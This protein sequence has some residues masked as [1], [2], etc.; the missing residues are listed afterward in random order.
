M[1]KILHILPLCLFAG[2][3]LQQYNPPAIASPAT[4]LVVEG[5]IDSG[6]DSTTFTLTQTFPLQTTGVATPTPQLGAK[7]TVQGSDN[8]SYPLGEVGGGVYGAQLAGL[9]PSVTYRLFIVTT[10]GKQYASDYVPLVSNPPI[11]SINWVRN[12]DGVQIY[13]NT[14]DPTGNAKYFRW[15]Y[16]ETWEF[17]SP[18][19]QIEKY[20]N[21]QLEAYFPN[22]NSTC[23]RSDVSTDILIASSTQ[24]SQDVLYEVPLVLVPANSQQISVEYSILVKQYALTQ[25]AFS[26]WGI[27]QNNTE[28]IGSIFG[29]QPTT[30]QGNL[31]CLTDTAEQVIGYISAGN[32]QSQRIFISDNQV[33]PWEYEPGCPDV[34]TPID[35]IYY[36]VGQGYELYA[37][38]IVPP[39]A[40]LSYPRCIDCTLTGSNVRPPFW[41]PG[42]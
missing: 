38:S 22:M 28:N 33:F 7:L 11:D 30:D 16:E 9:N 2:A 8:S 12:S 40:Y 39:D 23:W 6:P 21:G 1:K 18:Y 27:M 14:H 17:H 35:S 41:P 13:A 3:C 26:W 31:H 34:T 29:V 24:L 10:A 36:W 15:D 42:L 19:Y 37:T 32:S 5:F 4:Y 20:V 25:A